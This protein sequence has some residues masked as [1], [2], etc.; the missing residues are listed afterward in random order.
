MIFS[1]KAPDYE[2]GHL[3]SSDEK[4]QSHYV[5]VLFGLIRAQCDGKRCCSAVQHDVIGRRS[6][7]RL[8]PAVAEAS[9]DLAQRFGLR[10][11][12]SARTRESQV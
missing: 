7:M 1:C 11:L 3:V 5:L 4:D 6:V 9:G 2:F 12:S 8:G 10:L